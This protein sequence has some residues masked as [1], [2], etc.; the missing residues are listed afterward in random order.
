MTIT[1]SNESALAL[2]DEVRRLVAAVVAEDAVEPFNE[3]TRLG[4]GERDAVVARDGNDLVGMALSFLRGDGARE[5]ELAVV[6]SARRAGVATALV[7]A[8]A[9]LPR[10]GE[11]VA[12]AHGDLPGAA[13]L[14]A[15]FGAASTRSLYVLE[16]SLAD[17]ETEGKVEEAVDALAEGARILTFD[18]ERDGDR[19]VALNALVF[20]D[21]PEQGKLTRRDLAAREAEPWFNAED[22]LVLESA[23]GELIGYNWI[24]ITDDEAE[25]YVIGVHPEAA[26]RGY[27]RA[28]MSAAYARIR[29]RGYNAVSLYVD[30]ENVRA[31]ELYRLQG[32]TTRSYDAQ[33]TAQHTV[34]AK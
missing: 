15:K 34:V 19:W 26:G 24:K 20:A 2:A 9:E 11:L 18:S 10:E 13:P 29:E 3:A 31:V 8:T 25:I 22:F 17:L 7:E 30:G 6:P 12:W 5:F 32:F 21:H 1:V 14:A 23:A 27:A 33:Y 4:L 16:K 28:L